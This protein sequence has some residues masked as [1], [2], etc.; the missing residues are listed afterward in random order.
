MRILYLMVLAVSASCA[1]K[2]LTESDRL[3]D[4]DTP[5]SQDSVQVNG[6]LRFAIRDFPTG[7]GI[8]WAL[9][10]VTAGTQSI[11]VEHT[12]YGSLCRYAVAGRTQIQGNRIELHVD[13]AQRLTLCTADI[14]ALRY[15]ATVSGLSG[16]YEVAVIHEEGARSD[17]LALRTV[18]V[19]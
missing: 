19:H 14:R 12:R 13:F 18:T 8:F 2:A 3:I 5:A 1:G 16:T 7:G 15:T 17:T 9:P 11:V 10:S 6:S 4:T